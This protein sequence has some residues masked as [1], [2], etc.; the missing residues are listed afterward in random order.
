MAL[1]TQVVIGIDIDI[2]I[3]EK[4]WYLLIVKSVD[5]YW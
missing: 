3:R 2:D 5:T 1:C 4:Y